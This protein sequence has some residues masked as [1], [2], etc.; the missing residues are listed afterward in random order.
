[1]Y[2]TL[3]VRATGVLAALLILSACGA[4]I[5]DG[6]QLVGQRCFQDAECAEGLTCR[7]RLCVPVGGV[8]VDAPDQAVDLDPDMVVDLDMVVGPDMSVPDM[9]IPDMRPDMSEPDMLP[10]MALCSIGEQR[11]VNERVFEVCVSSAPGAPAQFVRRG[12]P[13]GQLCADGKCQETCVDRDGDGFF[14]NCEP[15]DCDDSSRANNPRARERCG[16]MVDNNC[17]MRVDEGCAQCCPNGCGPNQFCN[18]CACQPFDPGLCQFQGQ[19]CNTPDSFDNGYYCGDLTGTGQFICI[20]LC[21][22][23]Q[24]PQFTPC[25]DPSTSCIFVNPDDGA[26]TCWTDC[27]PGGTCGSRQLSCVP[28]EESATGASCFPGNPNNPIGAPCD[29]NSLFD[30]ANGGICLDLSFQ[31]LGGTCQNACRPFSLPGNQTDC[32][33]RQHCLP[34]APSIG[35]CRPDVTSREGQPCSQLYATCGEDGV[36]CQ[37]DSQGALRCRRICRDNLSGDCNA[38]QRCQPTNDGSGL[39]V[40]V[41]RGP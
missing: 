29:E 36:F 34:L 41:R 4:D 37:P 6:T 23:F 28:N 27:Q 3:I 20:G 5:S 38:N 31:G 26:G 15:F 25:P 14:G 1:M 18:N 24:G 16:D 33:A 8:P 22:T 17:D 19:P 39:G 21:G 40:C 7:A 32:P 12:C 35:V 11:C 30:C 2:K 13:A 10:D 9:S